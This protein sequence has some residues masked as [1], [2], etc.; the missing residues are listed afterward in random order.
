MTFDRPYLLIL[1]ALI[2][3]YWLFRVKFR[4]I[5]LKKLRTFVRPVLWEKV[6][7]TQPPSRLLS[8][9]LWTC[10]LI[11]LVFALSDPRWETEQ[12][13]VSS[14]GRNLVIALDVSQSMASQDEIPSR[15]GRAVIE[16]R[17]IALEFENT[18]IAL[19][20]FSGSS[21]LAVPLTLDREYIY[22]RLPFQAGMT[23]DLRSGTRLSDVVEMMATT[24][25]DMDLEASLGIIFSDGGF[26]D[27]SVSRATDAAVQNG[28]RII[29][30]GMGSPLEVP[31]PDPSGNLIVDAKGDTVR[32]TLNSE[33]LIQ[34]AEGTDGVYMR[35]SQTE[36]VPATIESYL[37]LLSL[38][39]SDL[40]AGG[41]T[42]GRKYQWFIGGALLLF[43]AALI[44][45]KRR[46]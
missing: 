39:N 42:A 10:G 14:G 28:M 9:A 34:L 46:L 4:Q 20:L 7:I 2:P 17:K 1:F 38:H 40:T 27:Y 30:V 45:E 5:E 24:L 12:A 16:I 22:S 37:D 26:Q 41:A 32:T 18:R 29:T 19:I 13:L 25:P 33:P 15:L 36:D 8:R 23:T 3:L 6:G 35:L 44:L 21:R 11:L 31:V 43:G